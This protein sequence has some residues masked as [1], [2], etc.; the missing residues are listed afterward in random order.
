MEPTFLHIALLPMI[1]A[2]LVVMVVH[3]TL[4]VIAR[5]KRLVDCPNARK[6][7]KHPVPV[8]GGVG[9]LF[10]LTVGMGLAGYLLPRMALPSEVLIGMTVLLYA[11]VADDILDLSPR[12]KFLV[13]G[14]AV[15]M[16]AL[17][18]EMYID[19][20]Y[21][22]WGLYFLPEWP[23]VALTLVAGVGIIN[24]MNMIDG[25]DG[26][27]ALYA[28]YASLIFGVGFLLADDRE[29]ALLAF[30]TF[31]ALIPF[32]LHNIYGSKYKMFLGDGGSLVIGFICVVYVMRQ[33]QTAESA[34]G[35]SSIAFAFAVMAVPVCD[36]LRVMTQ[37]VVQHRSPFS[38]D[39]NHLHHLFIELGM[40]H[41][42][43]AFTV[44]GLDVI[45]VGVW[46][47]SLGAGADAEWQLL[48]TIVAAAVLTWGLYYV[49][50][51]ASRRDARM[52]RRLRW[53]TRRSVMRRR[54]FAER[55]R[56]VLDDK[57]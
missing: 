2:S 37:R 1:V 5:R 40:D 34:F 46:M 48:A 47:I 15:L 39:K 43:T 53:F 21:G 23:A 57:T 35:G 6:L 10:G 44:V 13:Q 4:V 52:V 8:L 42:M 16:L 50:W 29:Y 45:I 17:A 26:L 31:G 27:C 12:L 32:M 7:N 19:N 14:F 18:A 22:L 11:G 25:V 33:L 56:R 51:R 20:L 30:A 41:S 36:T 55:L 54:A 9:V 38:P 24:A 3:P 28:A 49:T